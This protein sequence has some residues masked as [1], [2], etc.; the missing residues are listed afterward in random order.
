MNMQTNSKTEPLPIPMTFIG[1][2]QFG[3]KLCTIF[4]DGNDDSFALHK[5]K[6]KYNVHQVYPNARCLV[7]PYDRQRA[8]FKEFTPLDTLTKQHLLIFELPKGV[9]KKTHNRVL[10]ELIAHLTNAEKAIVL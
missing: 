1:V 8:A 4:Q 10:Q 9:Y 2:C 6:N 7:G 5:L 3:G